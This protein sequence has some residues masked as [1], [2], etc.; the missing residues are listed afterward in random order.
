MIDRCYQGT[1]DQ[2]LM[3]ELVHRNPAVNVHVIALPYRLSSWALDDPENARLWFDDSGILRAWAV[4]QSPF[5][6]I[7]YAFD[8]SHDYTHDFDPR[9]LHGQIL[10][11]AIARAQAVLPDPVYGRPEWYINVLEGQAERMAELSAKGFADQINAPVDPLSMVFL[12]RPAQA[13]LQQKRSSPGYRLRELNGQDEVSA[14]VALHQAVFGTKNMTED[15]RARVIQHTAYRPELD[16][17]IEAPDG[18]LAAFCV[19]WFDPAGYG[20]RPCGQI[21]PL[22]VGEHHR[23]PGLAKFLLNECCHRMQA[24]GAEQITVQTDNFRNDALALYLSAGFYL[25][26][27]IHVFRKDFDTG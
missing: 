6:S 25:W 18:S 13:A 1:T 4:L 22:G 17:V 23:H 2:S 14:Y 26:Q 11:W 3:L 7:D 10:D 5:W 8:S 21:E 27:V 19:G 15:W 16:L 9:V 24:L 20:G 12:T